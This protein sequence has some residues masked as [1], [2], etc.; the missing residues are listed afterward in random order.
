LKEEEME[1]EYLVVRIYNGKFGDLLFIGKNVEVY[2]N[3]LTGKSMIEILDWA[4]KFGWE[5]S[6][7]PITSSPVI[8]RL[9]IYFKRPR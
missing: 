5:M 9:D 1:W 3:E 7:N 6:G 2:I 8:D 4:G